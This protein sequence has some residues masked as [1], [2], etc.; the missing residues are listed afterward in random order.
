M[1]FNQ[2][3]LKQARRGPT[4]ATHRAI[5]AALGVMD[6]HPAR[7][8]FVFPHWAMAAAAAVAVVALVAAI[9]PLRHRATNLALDALGQALPQADRVN[10][11]AGGVAPLPSANASPQNDISAFLLHQKEYPY[12]QLAQ[13]AT[14]I[15][16][17]Q[18]V[19][20]ITAT[21]KEAA[22]TV[23]KL[24]LVIGLADQPAR[25]DIWKGLTIAVNEEDTPYS[26]FG[27]GTYYYVTARLPG[28]IKAPGTPVQ[29]RVSF[30]LYEYPEGNAE[31]N[32]LGNYTFDFTVTMGNVL[33]QFDDT[34]DSLPTPAPS[35]EAT[36]QFSL[37]PP[38]TVMPQAT[39]EAVALASS[40]TVAAQ[41]TMMHTPN[42]SIGP[43]PSAMPSSAPKAT[44]S[45]VI[46][47]S[48]TWSPPAQGGA[49]TEAL[50]FSEANLPEMPGATYAGLTQ[51]NTGIVLEMPNTLAE[52]EDKSWLTT[53]IGKK[54]ELLVGWKGN[55]GSFYLCVGNY[56]MDGIW[57][58]A[59]YV[60]TQWK[61]E[62]NGRIFLPDGVPVVLMED[63][64]GQLA[65]LV[66][67][68]ADVPYKMNVSA[69]TIT[70][71]GTPAYIHHALKTMKFDGTVVK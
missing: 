56:A 71:W 61:G 41:A 45:A 69:D 52:T 17:S 36:A 12:L 44:A 43:E 39:A 14:S 48:M 67:Q 32:L 40:A 4:P 9:P 59:N 31:G 68:P 27:D 35:A 70:I 58:A 13:I 47:P 6:K 30:D 51:Q 20:G 63:K 54:T 21:V 50:V 55:S 49:N 10:P 66:F 28:I 24:Y 53:D 16:A 60:A 38:S 23:D 62:V 57:K 1:E 26:G 29:T 22:L 25:S 2:E 34:V 11:A 19:N 65:C 7:T 15:N 8:P 46:M 64:Q 37:A 5:L 18:T 33:V 3:N 42:P